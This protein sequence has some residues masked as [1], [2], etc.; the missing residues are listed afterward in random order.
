MTISGP[1]T[2]T[3]DNGPANAVI[4][5]SGTQNLSA[6][7]V[8]NGNTNVTVTSS[9]D[10]FTVSGNV[11]GGGG[12]NLLGA[13]MLALSGTNSY[14]GG[15]TVST[16]TLQLGSANALGSGGLTL[17]GGV[18]D[19]AGNSPAAL[20]S[21]NGAA[22]SI[23]TNSLAGAVT[24]TVDPT[25][26][27]VFSGTLQNGSGTLSLSMNGPGQLTLSGSNTYSG[28][29]TVLAGTLQL[30]NAQR[31]GHR[32]PDRSTAESSTWPATAPRPCP[33]LNGSPGSIITSS[34]AGAVTL[35]VESHRREHLRRRVAKWFGYTL[36]SP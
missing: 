26:P 29:T 1:N 21:L 32:R 31:P 23:I 16:G 17:S 3:L 11:S 36:R 18:V 19:L 13:G 30:G 25:T 15:T 33:S 27:S 6:A 28:G 22:G 20:P 5:V 34:S 35:T 2:L 4:L 9:S 12:L 8:L 24:L 7:T 14:G 10:S